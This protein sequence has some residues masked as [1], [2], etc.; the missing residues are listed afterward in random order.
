[1]S[2]DR[3]PPGNLELGSLEEGSLAAGDAV[4]ALY[5]VEFIDRGHAIYP[6]SPS[7]L[8]LSAG[9]PIVLNPGAQGAVIYSEDCE[10]RSVRIAESLFI[11]ACAEQRL[12]KP[13]GRIEFTSLAH[14]FGALGNLLPVLD[15]FSQELASGTATPQILR[16]YQLLIAS[17]F[18]AALPYSIRFSPLETQSVPFD[19]LVLYIEENLKRDISVE[20]LARYANMSLRSLYLVF[21]KNAKAT[22]KDFI[23]QKKLEQVYAALINPASTLTNVTAAALE[24]GFT[25]LGRFSEFYK[26]TFGLL[27]SESL[28]MR[29]GQALAARDDRQ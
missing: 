17:K 21:E 15:L 20:E 12:G 8:K 7:P 6:G 19:R 25:H 27:P 28:K 9:Q 18:L 5:Q 22:P 2:D 4:P 1:M 14:E 13:K 16:Y 3:C 11:E 29:Q 23:R 26:T 10:K 24:Y